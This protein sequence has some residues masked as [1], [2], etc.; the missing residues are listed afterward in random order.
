MNNNLT[1]REEMAESG[2]ELS[3]GVPQTA[4]TVS[5][6]NGSKRAATLVDEEVPANRVKGR[7]A[8]I[9]ETPEHVLTKEPS[10]PKSVLKNVSRVLNKP[11]SQQQ[12]QWFVPDM[13]IYRRK[14]KKSIASSTTITADSAG[15]S[16]SGIDMENDSAELKKRK[17]GRPRKY[18]AP[19]LSD[20]APPT[21]ALASS[22][23]EVEERNQIE[24]SRV[25]R[26][27]A[28]T[29]AETSE[30]QKRKG[31]RP[32]KLTS[33]SKQPII[34]SASSESE[35]EGDTILNVVARETVEEPPK[36]KKGR[37]PKSSRGA[38]LAS[39]ESEVEEAEIPPGEVEHGVLEGTVT[40][41]SPKKRRGRPRKSAH[42]ATS[43]ESDLEELLDTVR[44][45]RRHKG[46]AQVGKSDQ[47][48]QEKESFQTSMPA[49]DE[50]R[51]EQQVVESKKSEAKKVRGRSRKSQA[52]AEQSASSGSEM[53]GKKIAQEYYDEV[54]S[55][56][57][58]QPKSRRGRPRK[59]IPTEPAASASSESELEEAIEQGQLYVEESQGESGGGESGESAHLEYEGVPVKK[60]EAKRG[61]GRLHKSAAPPTSESEENEEE[62]LIKEAKHRG[63][64]PPVHPPPA[65]PSDGLVTGEEMS[66]P[67]KK[68]KKNKKAKHHQ[69]DGENLN[70]FVTQGG[71]VEDEQQPIIEVGD[72]PQSYDNVGGGNDD[73][74][75]PASPGT[76][77]DH[78]DMASNFVQ[79][80]TTPGS[81]GS[82]GGQQAADLS[83]AESVDVSVLPRLIKRKR[84]RNNKLVLNPRSK[85]RK[86]NKMVD[87]TVQDPSSLATPD[88]RGMDPHI[89]SM[90]TSG[91]EGEEDSDH[92]EGVE[93][94]Q[95]G[96]GRK[97]RRLRVEPKKSHTPGVRR[98]KRT[99][100]APVR[101]W[102]NEQLEYNLNTSGKVNNNCVLIFMGH[103]CTD[104]LV[105][106]AILMYG[107][108]TNVYHTLYTA[109]QVQF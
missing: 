87:G 26:E 38:T 55:D 25:E 9:S 91:E 101:H 47:A 60:S 41:E 5:A 53:E 11:T 98:S 27:P 37:P 62:E 17:R 80:T 28:R 20:T 33:P 48:P 85:K 94:I 4:S 39:S 7:R 58:E 78:V 88:G 75:S 46:G 107:L 93:I 13:D 57:M 102:E 12:S 99:R 23:S 14:K 71:A 109:L 54:Q 43:S 82:R 69:T 56:E 92:F 16:T 35:L 66:Q 2:N 79:P 1:T 19:P 97:Y 105:K 100:I 8:R 73:Y 67:K 31:G 29:M 15:V 3:D 68:K 103:L 59:V 65:A 77:D 45:N 30:P 52:V 22:E 42:Q 89:Y 104:P 61:R 49:T 21:V 64:P 72:E 81:A 83:G 6:V 90:S 84:A 34:A 32:P 96:G 63:V 74:E 95:S 10:S 108:L 51:L 44:Q 24:I 40:L 86:K 18:V 106:S 36:K 50:S 70:N 76:Y